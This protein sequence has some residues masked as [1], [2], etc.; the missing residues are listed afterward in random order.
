MG[1]DPHIASPREAV[2]NKAALPFKRVEIIDDN[3]LSVVLIVA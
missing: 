2:R 3:A 1:E